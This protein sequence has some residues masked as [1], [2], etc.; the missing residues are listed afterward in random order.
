MKLLLYS[1]VHWSE[2][3][4][5]VRS[6][7]NKY[8]TRLEYLINSMNWVESMAY[9]NQCDASICLGDFFDKPQLNAREI[10]AL[11]E[12]TWG[13]H[14]HYFIVGNH[15]IS[16]SDLYM[17]SANLFEI[18]PTSKVISNPSMLFGNIFVLP[19]ILNSNRLPLKEYLTIGKPEIILSHNDIAGIQM[20]QFIS[21]DGF[22]IEEIEEN[23][24]IF[25]NGHIHNA[26]KISNNIFNI[27]NLCGQNFS[28]DASKYKHYIWILD[29]ETKQASTYENPYALNFYKF[30]FCQSNDFN[31][32]NNVYKNS[33]LTIK[34]FDK[35]KQEIKQIINSLNNIVAS[36]FL[37]EYKHKNLEELSVNDNIQV[38]HLKQFNDYILNNSQVND[39]LLEELNEVLK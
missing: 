21:K 11:K 14:P 31:E 13:K 3:S 19:Y 7:G 24:D 5:I 1:D 27:G 36:R 22:T 32:L 9:E 34:C 20:G 33:V 17:N 10:S 25:I 29:T 18:L 12:V 4:S 2:F 23:C 26:D 37:I 8:S 39:V 35:D 38:D 6:I 15:E 30:D 28:E 16:S